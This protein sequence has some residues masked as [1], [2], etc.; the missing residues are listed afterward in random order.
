VTL[1]NV[2]DPAVTEVLAR[3]TVPEVVIV[4]PLKPVP[5]VI[6]VIVPGLPQDVLVPLVVK[7]LPEL[8][9]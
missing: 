3:A 8:P 9:V 1:A 7:N 2:Y 4:P 5:A 6:L